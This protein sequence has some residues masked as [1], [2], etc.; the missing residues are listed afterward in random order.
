MRVEDFLST[1]SRKRGDPSVGTR[2]SGPGDRESGI[3]IHGVLVS[4][5]SFANAFLGVAILKE[6]ALQIGFMRLDVFRSTFHRRTHLGLN[7]RLSCRIRRAPGQLTAQLFD[8]SLGN[9]GLDGE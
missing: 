9:L 1:L 3:E 7:F 4:S 8:D 6:A 5:Q 2:D